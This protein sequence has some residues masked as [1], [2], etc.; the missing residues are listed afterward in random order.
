M[1]PHASF[2]SPAFGRNKQH[3]G[4]NWDNGKML[5][6]SRRMFR[7]RHDNVLPRVIKARCLCSWAHGYGPA[8][9][10][11]FLC[12][13]RFC[14]FKC[15]NVHSGFYVRAYHQTPHRIK[16]LNKPNSVQLSQPRILTQNR[17]QTHEVTLNLKRCQGSVDAAVKLWACCCW[18]LKLLI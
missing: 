11:C 8:D 14:E 18:A 17:Q 10:I 9:V 1:K 2:L 7:W 12:A 4:G 3:L 6:Q 16:G 13:N 15:R 5:D